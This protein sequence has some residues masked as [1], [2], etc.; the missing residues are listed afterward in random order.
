MII[1]NT[2]HYFRKVWFL[3][4]RGAFGTTPPAAEVL[5]EIIRDQGKSC[6]TTVHYDADPDPVGFTKNTDT[7]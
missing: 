5:C 7:K 1:E 6:R 3:P 4:G 2:A